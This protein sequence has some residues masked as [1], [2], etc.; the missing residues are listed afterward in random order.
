MI[1]Y[2]DFSIIFNNVLYTQVFKHHPF[3]KFVPINILAQNSRNKFY[4]MQQQPSSIKYMCG[5]SIHIKTLTNLFYQ[6]LHR[7][8]LEITRKYFTKMFY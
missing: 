4:K 2:L 7:N 3:V 6:K 1:L 5:F 8:E